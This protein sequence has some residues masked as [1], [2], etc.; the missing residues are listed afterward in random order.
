MH[1]IKPLDVAE[2][3]AAA[4]DAEL[5]VTVEEHTRI[6]G[7]GS[8]VA[9]TFADEGIAQPLLRLG[10]PDAFSH[11]YGNQDHVLNLAGLSPAAIAAGVLARLARRPVGVR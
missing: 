3:L 10:L 9:E 2:L 11:D 7:L 8:A 1:T 5:V 6:G 4:G